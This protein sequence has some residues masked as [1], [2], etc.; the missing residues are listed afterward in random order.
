MERRPNFQGGNKKYLKQHH[1]AFEG[2]IMNKCHLL[3]HFLGLCK[4][5]DELN[6]MKEDIIA[7]RK[8]TTK[9]L[10]QFNKELNL[11]IKDENIRVTL[12]NIKKVSK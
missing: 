12:T 10:K 11:I 6:S 9:E 2:K 1:I 5:D 8:K 3:K 7:G 4:C